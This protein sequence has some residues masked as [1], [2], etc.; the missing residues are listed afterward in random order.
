MPRVII[1]PP[2][3]DASV[4]RN[5]AMTGRECT[6]RFFF[7]FSARIA[8]RPCLRLSSCLSVS[9][10]P[11]CE[12]VVGTAP[13]SIVDPRTNSSRLWESGSALKAFQTCVPLFITRASAFA[14]GPRGEGKQTTLFQ[15]G[16]RQFLFDA[17]GPKLLGSLGTR[18]LKVLE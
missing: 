17:Q 3:L 12:V 11:G 14:A 9:P 16:L 15:M 13:R 4:A 18:S 6:I 7:Q 5:R 1:L 8:V 10:V 2:S